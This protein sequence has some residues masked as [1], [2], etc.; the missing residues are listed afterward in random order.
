MQASK[1][2]AVLA[3]RVVGVAWQMLLCSMRGGG[4]GMS[5]TVAILGIPLIDS[6]HSRTVLALA[7][8][9]ILALTLALA[10]V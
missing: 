2:K 3:S 7:L 8:A 4:G 1:S 5:I 6:M 10:I 9:I